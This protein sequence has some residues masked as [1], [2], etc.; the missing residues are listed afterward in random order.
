MFDDW[1]AF[2]APWQT[3][4]KATLLWLQ[5]ALRRSW[6]D[7]GRVI[8]FSSGAA[9][10]GSPLSGGYAG[11]KQT[12]R[13]LCKYAAGEARMRELPL[14]IQ[15]LLPQLNPNTALGLA[16]VRAYAQRAGEDPAAFVHKRFGDVPLSPA[17]AGEQVVRLLVDPTL[18]STP[19][20]LLGGRGL[21]A[22]EG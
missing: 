19:E 8:V 11:A 5:H 4:V 1:E 15:C 14:T 18:Q 13:F 20:F 17:I 3:D 12:Q 16:G 7:H 10:F 9:M 22:I 6:R 21:K 2:S